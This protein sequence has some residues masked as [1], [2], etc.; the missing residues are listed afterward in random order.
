[1]PSKYSPSKL[2]VMI[3][4]PRSLSA[5]ATHTALW[6]EISLF[7]TQT[8]SPLLEECSQGCLFPLSKTHQLLKEDGILLQKSESDRDDK[9][10]TQ[11]GRPPRQQ[12]LSPRMANEMKVRPQ[13]WK[14]VY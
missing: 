4:H 7:K 12:C 13:T 9:V 11:T 8:Q 10:S 3:T 5:Q 6:G 1:M 14:K 2:V